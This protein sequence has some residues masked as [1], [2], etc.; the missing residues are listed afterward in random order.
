MNKREK[1]LFVEILRLL[2]VCSYNE[3]NLLDQN[4]TSM[5]VRDQGK[6]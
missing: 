1:S 6:I 4:K 3:P 5:L 2:N